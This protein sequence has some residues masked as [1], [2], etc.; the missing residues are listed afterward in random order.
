MEEY[1]KFEKEADRLEVLI[2]RPIYTWILGIVLV[3]YALI[4]NI[5]ISIQGLIVLITGTR[6]EGLNNPIKN[7]VEYII[8][9]YPYM[10]ALTDERPEI[11]HAN[12]KV[13]LEVLGSGSNMEE[14]LKFESEA[15]RLEVLIIRP[16]YNCI[17][18]IVL[19]IYALIAGI[20]QGIQWWIILITGARNEGLANPIKNYIQFEIQIAPYRYSLTDERPQITPKDVKIFLE[21]L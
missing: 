4:A 6:N 8:Q 7:Y 14:F 5:C 19:V 13:Y 10:S 9:I 11:S 18:S 12:M 16:I 2:I 15:S 20:C 1:L 3:I 17:L 21:R